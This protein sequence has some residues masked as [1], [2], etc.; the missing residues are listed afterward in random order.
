MKCLVVLVRV[1]SLFH[2]R[3]ILL[4]DDSVHYTLSE[5]TVHQA[6]FGDERDSF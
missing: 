1:P 6:A 4:L 2:G 3:F 5:Q